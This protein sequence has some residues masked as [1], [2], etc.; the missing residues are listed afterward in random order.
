MKGFYKYTEDKKNIRENIGLLVNEMGDLV[1]QDMGK[2]EVLNAFFASVFCSKTSLQES[3]APE[4][5]M[6]GWNKKDLSL[7]EEDHVREY[8]ANWTYI[9][10]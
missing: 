6:K 1:T 3:Q 9:I 4:I 8:L 10:P 2:A 5:R 7:V